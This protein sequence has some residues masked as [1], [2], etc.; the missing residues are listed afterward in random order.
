MPIVGRSFPRSRRARGSSP[1]ASPHPLLGRQHDRQEVGPA[2]LAEE[3]AA[4]LSSVSALE[5]SGID[6]SKLDTPRSSAESRRVSG[7]I[8][9]CMNGVPLIGSSPST[10]AAKLSRRFFDHRGRHEGL[11]G[12]RHPVDASD[13]LDEAANDVA[14]EPRP[15][16]RR[17]STRVS[18]RGRRPPARTCFR[19]LPRG[20]P[21][22]R[23]TGSLTELGVRA[24][25]SFQRTIS[26]RIAARAPRTSHSSVR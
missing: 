16:E 26:V 22:R 11:A 23:R 2:V 10:Y 13:R 15:S 3:V 12:A 8:T 17:T 9:S 1:R 7:S 19:G 6:R 25:W 21:R 24:C 14:R 18:S 5:E 20:L 4:G